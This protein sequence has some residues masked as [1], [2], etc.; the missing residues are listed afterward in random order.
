MRVWIALLAVV[1]AFA[2]PASAR[3]PPGP[4]QPL[5]ASL[6]TAPELSARTIVE[7][8][9]A[10][11]G[12]ETWRRPKTLKLT[13]YAV[14]YRDGKPTVHERYEFNRVFPE[15]KPDAH[16]ADGKVRIRSTSGAKPGINLAFDGARSYTA[17]GLQPPSEAD[18]Q[19]A[20]NFGFG[21]IRFALD[22][23]YK[24][25]RL[26]DDLVD[27]AAAFVIV[28]IDP[29]GGKTQFAIRQKDF[30]VVRVGF[31][32]DR[33]WHERIYSD[34]WTKPGVSWVQPGRIRLF[35][36]GVKQNELIWRDFE[37]NAPMSDDLFVI[38]AAS[39]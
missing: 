21:V 2:A 25:E 10:A 12:G 34:F 1:L 27:G 16:R 3:P 7:R 18:K 6:P 5:I 35:Y 36:D 20:E 24:L 4:D 31:R 29:A 32:T 22:D 19:W 30:A 11:A 33:G 15:F 14:F 13:G 8:A 9:T 17:A 39:P 38:A 28:V 23:G 26:A 37:L